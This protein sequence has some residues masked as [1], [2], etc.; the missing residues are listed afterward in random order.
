MAPLA[1]APLVLGEVEVVG[2][3]PVVVVRVTMPLVWPPVVVAVEL[4]LVWVVTGGVAEVTGVLVV[5]TVTAVVLLLLLWV[6]V[7]VP[8][9]VVVEEVVGGAAELEVE[10]P[11]WVAVEVVGSGEPGLRQTASPASRVLSM[12]ERPSPQWAGS[13]VASPLQARMMSPPM[14]NLALA[15]AQLILVPEGRAFWGSATAR[16][17]AAR[18]MAAA[19]FMMAVVC[20]KTKVLFVCWWLM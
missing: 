8:V 19:V 5:V 15:L 11:V 16:V 1:T 6:P 4:P 17:A 9:P 13:P 3:P 12:H 18:M 20:W 14:Q 10:V 7:P 2:L